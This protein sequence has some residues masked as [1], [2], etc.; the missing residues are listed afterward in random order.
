MTQ[1]VETDAAISERVRDARCCMI[2]LGSRA[3]MECLH[4]DRP[5]FR[6]LPGKQ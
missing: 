1:T 2:T 6:T 3:G 4:R 5:W